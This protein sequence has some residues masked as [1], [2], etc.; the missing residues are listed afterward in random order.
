MLRESGRHTHGASAAGEPNVLA[1]V[2]PRARS[3]CAAG[4]RR[5]ASIYI[6]ANSTTSTS[7]RSRAPGRRA[8]PSAAPRPVW[9]TPSRTWQLGVHLD[10]RRRP[11]EHRARRE[12]EGRRH[13]RR[14]P[15]RRGGIGISPWPRATCTAAGAA[16]GVTCARAAREREPQGGR[17]RVDAGGDDEG[18]GRPRSPRSGAPRSAAVVN[19]Y[20][21]GIGGG[22]TGAS[23]TTPPRHRPTTT[24][25]PP[26]SALPAPPPPP[27]G[28]HRRRRRCRRQLRRRH[29]RGAHPRRALRRV[30]ARANQLRV[31]VPLVAPRA[32]STAVDFVQPAPGTRRARASCRACACAPPPTARRA[33]RG[34]RRRWRRGTART[35]RPAALSSAPSAS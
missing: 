27:P 28:A 29:Q 26:P 15:L 35:V 6:E 25:P 9:R 11:A 12:V 23:T 21:A 30:L 2:A 4:S 16:P 19:K 31:L 20:A 3:S 10:R 33:P 34:G 5:G 14:A 22:G 17:R 1:A 18:G 24:P 32:V 7:S 13:R 8:A